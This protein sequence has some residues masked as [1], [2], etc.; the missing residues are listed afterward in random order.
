MTGRLTVHYRNPTPLNREL[1]FRGRLDRVEG[2]KIFTVATLHCDEMLC[3]E[4]EGLFI[5][6]PQDRFRQ[7]AEDTD[8]G[9]AEGAVHAFGTAAAE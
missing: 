7:L 9:I 3:A 5:S 6:V 1:T 8:R 2:R 4:S